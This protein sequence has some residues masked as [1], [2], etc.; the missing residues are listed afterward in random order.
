MHALV[1][2]LETNK[3]LD[4]SFIVLIPHSPFLGVLS[5]TPRPPE[6]A[7][8]QFWIHECVTSP[9]VDT[10]NSL[11]ALSSKPRLHYFA[12]VYEGHALAKVGLCS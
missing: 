4:L 6:S 12:T 3:L 8:W 5:K 2:Y 10:L 11:F 7:G 1:A 9:S